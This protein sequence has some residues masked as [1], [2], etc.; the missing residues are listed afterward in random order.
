MDRWRT[1]DEDADSGGAPAA[2]LHV[3]QKL[4]LEQLALLEL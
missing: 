2:K 1:I 3:S 4:E